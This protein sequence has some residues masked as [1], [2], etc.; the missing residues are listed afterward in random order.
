MTYRLWRRYLSGDTLDR[1]KIHTFVDVD[2]GK[3]DVEPPHEPQ[4]FHNFRRN[5]T[6]MVAVARAHGATPVLLT[7]ASRPVDAS[8]AERRAGP[9]RS[10]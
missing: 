9:A 1:R 6:S 8:S 5:L 10:V 4:G 7:Q 2:V 3:L